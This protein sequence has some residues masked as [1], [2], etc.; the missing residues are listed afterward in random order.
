MQTEATLKSEKTTKA[1]TMKASSKPEKGTS[2]GSQLLRNPTYSS[3]EE[4]E[5]PFGE[6]RRPGPQTIM[7]SL[8]R[9]KRPKTRREKTTISA[10][11]SPDKNAIVVQHGIHAHKS[12]NPIS[13]EMRAGGSGWGH[14]EKDGRTD[15]EKEGGREPLSSFPVAMTTTPPAISAAVFV[16]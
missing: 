2:M 5:V 15:G 12:C 9:V 14:E 13:S 1:T 4:E 7:S 16:I 3:R 8:H 6:A 11:S 10:S